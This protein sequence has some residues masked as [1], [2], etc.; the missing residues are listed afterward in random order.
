MGYSSFDD[1]LSRGMHFMSVNEFKEA[2]NMKGAVLIDTR[3]HSTFSLG[4]IPGSIF[5]GIDDNFAPWMGVL[6]ED[7]DAP[8]LMIADEGREE[9][10]I[11]R[12]ARVGYDHP[13][14]FLKGGVAAWVNE[15]NPIESMSNVTPDAFSKEFIMKDLKVLDVRK[16]SEYN[17]QHLDG[18]QNFPLDFIYQHLDELNPEEHYYVHCAGGYRSVAA[19]S[20][21]KKFGVKNVTNIL[22]GFNAMKLEERLPL[23]GFHEQTTML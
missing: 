20:I 2:M 4:F 7:L 16:L 18:A 10:V 8:V 14:G 23:S 21:M 3:H 11:T 5:I 12:M 15:G 6:I 9:E 1:V 13:M 19:A 22:G 17:S